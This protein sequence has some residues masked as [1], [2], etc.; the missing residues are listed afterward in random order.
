MK[1]FLRLILVTALVLALLSM[2]L[3]LLVALN[4]LTQP[5]FSISINGSELPLA[6]LHAGHWL[7]GMMGLG[8]AAVVVVVV[9]PLAL[10]MGLAMPLL[11]LALGL[12]LGLLALLGVGALMLSPLLLLALLLLWLARKSRRPPQH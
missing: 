11:M 7:L 12:S 5:D 8:I 9:V 3:G 4:V 6:E 10:L 2:A 1:S